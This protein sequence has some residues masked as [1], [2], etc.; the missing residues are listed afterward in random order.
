MVIDVALGLGEWDRWLDD[1]DSQLGPMILLLY[2]FEL[3]L[4]SRQRQRQQ[5]SVGLKP[6]RSGFCSGA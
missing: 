6:H 1:W 5:Y 4:V 2:N 3:M